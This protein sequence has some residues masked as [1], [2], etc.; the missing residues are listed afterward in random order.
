MSVT[1]SLPAGLLVADPPVAS[2]DCI[3]GSVT[4][5]AGGNQ[6][7]LSGA[8]MSPQTNCS[9]QLNVTAAA[10]GAYVNTI[11]KDSVTS[12]NGV[13]NN[14][15]DATATLN[16]VNAPVIS[17]TFTPSAVNAGVVSTLKVTIANSNTQPLTGAALTDNLPSGLTVTTTPNA[18][19]TCTG[20]GVSVAAAV[21]GTSI[22]LTNATIPANGSCT[23]QADVASNTPAAY[24]NS[25][26]I[27]ALSTLEGASNTAKG[28]ATPYRP[29]AADGE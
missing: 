2:T 25:I 21:G 26:P 11:P 17:K 16:V 14:A 12:A 1:D 24:A 6:V 19:T 22:G 5:A 9:V 4:A 13:T 20:T 23:F 28:D 3:S 18:S 7:T 15:N 29:A 27:G 8:A 10:L